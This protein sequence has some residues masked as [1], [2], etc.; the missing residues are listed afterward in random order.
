MSCGEGLVDVFERKDD[1][2]ARLGQI[3][4]VSGARTSFFAREL[5][6]LCVGVRAS[7]VEPAAIWVLRPVP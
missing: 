4:T 3:P 6:R 2:Y 1:G 5:D 7:G